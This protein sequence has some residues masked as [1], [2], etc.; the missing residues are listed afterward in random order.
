MPELG[1]ILGI[2]ESEVF[3]AL[4]SPAF[5]RD[6]KFLKSDSRIWWILSADKSKTNSPFDRLMK[7]IAPL[8]IIERM[9]HKSP[10]WLKLQ[11]EGQ[12]TIVVDSLHI[13]CK[14]LV[15]EPPKG[16][17][18]KHNGGRDTQNLRSTRIGEKIKKSLSVIND[19]YYQFARTKDRNL[20]N[21]IGIPP[22]LT[23]D[24]LKLYT[25][26]NQFLATLGEFTR[27][28]ED[29]E[30]LLL[31]SYSRLKSRV[32]PKHFAPFLAAL[33]LSLRHEFASSQDFQVNLNSSTLAK[34]LENQIARK[35]SNRPDSGLPKRRNKQ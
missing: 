1:A 33:E 35:K 6:Q 28:L 18:T 31:R 8:W 23:Q 19:S 22:L 5:L 17:E 7:V 9:A 15:A 14:L 32:T 20:V 12:Q 25:A 27:N 29:Q 21:Q 26:T 3:K 30:L 4:E 24:Y 16:F 11:L 10:H 13:C 34:R 2:S